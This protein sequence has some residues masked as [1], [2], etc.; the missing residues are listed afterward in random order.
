MLQARCRRA[1]RRARC[2]RGC[3]RFR[4]PASR[5]ARARRGAVRAA[6]TRMG[7]GARP[8]SLLVQRRRPPGCACRPPHPPGLPGVRRTARPTTVNGSHSSAYVTCEPPSPS[9]S[10][11]NTGPKRRNGPLVNTR[12][13]RKCRPAIHS[14]GFSS[15]SRVK[16][17]ALPRPRRRTVPFGLQRLLERVR[18]QAHRLVEPVGIG[19][20]R[21][22]PIRRQVERPGPGATHR[23]EL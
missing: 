2:R 22:E 17:A 21:P 23:L 15:H 14:Y 11:S 3:D 20:H 19:Q 5:P 13:W 7:S 6:A 4:G 8:H 9:D 10:R 12:D 1:A 16:P 18:R